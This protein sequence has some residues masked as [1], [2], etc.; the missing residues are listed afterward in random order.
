MKEIITKRIKQLEKELKALE[1]KRIT[2]ND[3]DLY[4]EVYIEITL[5]KTQI[6]LLNQMLEQ[7]NFQIVL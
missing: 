6:N 7:E 2:M 4:R 3:V 5:H 1:N